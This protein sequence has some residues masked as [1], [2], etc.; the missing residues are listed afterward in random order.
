[1]DFLKSFR[2]VACM[3]TG[4]TRLLGHIY[5]LCGRN[6]I[7]VKSIRVYEDTPPFDLLMVIP[8]E[9]V[10]QSRR[11]ASDFASNCLYI[12]DS[13]LSCIWKLTIEDNNKL[14]K[15][16]CGLIK[17]MSLT[18]STDG[19]VVVLRNG[20]TSSELDIYEPKGSLVRTVVMSNIVG[21]PFRFIRI[22]ITDTFIVVSSSNEI[23]KR[24]NGSTTIWLSLVSSNGEIV[25]HMHV[26]VDDTETINNTDDCWCWKIYKSA[27]E[28]TV[29]FV[30]SPCDLYL[31]LEER[32]I[33]T[34]LCFETK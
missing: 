22:G 26:H 1:M 13:D 16:V 30:F 11:L 17:P 9:E 3:L 34:Y 4:V 15:W 21:F 28:F 6:S 19:Q 18:A 23:G 5:I 20:R 8:I 7:S 29:D 10:S 31:L 24:F 2:R 12:L 14:S 27:L 25:S 32:I 33:P